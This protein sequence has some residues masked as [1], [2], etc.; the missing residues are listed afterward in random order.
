M[1]F[2]SVPTSIELPL[3]HPRS[4]IREFQGAV[5]LILLQ[6]HLVDSLLILSKMEGVPLFTIILSVFEVLLHRY[7][8]QEDLVVGVDP[9]GLAFEKLEGLTSS[10]QPILPMRLDLSGDPSFIDLLS[11][12]RVM[13][14]EGFSHPE[15]SRESIIE[16]LDPTRSSN[17]NPY[18]QVVFSFQNGEQNGDNAGTVPFLKTSQ[19][20][21]AYQSDLT[22]R[23]IQEGNGIHGRMEYNAC[24]F[25]PE[26]IRRMIGHLQ[27]LLQEVVENPGKKISQYQLLTES[28]R[29]LTLIDWNDTKVKFPQDATLQSLFEEQVERSPD[30]IA[31]V[32]E[33]LSMTYHQLNCKSNQLAH[34]LRNLGVGPDTRVGVCLERSFEMVEALLGVIKSGA[35]YVPLDPEYP[36][37]RLDFMVSDCN[38]LVLLTQFQHRKKLKTNQI[39]VLVLDDPDKAWKLENPTNPSRT[40]SSQNPAYMIYT[41]GSTGK[42][43]GVINSHQGICNRLLWGQ[44]KYPLDKEDAVLQRTTFS[45]DIS[46]WEIFWP[47]LNGVRLVLAKP[48][49]HRDP[50]YL[51]GLIYREKITTMHFVMSMM[52]VFLQI[53][54]LQLCRSLKRVLCSGEAMTP[55]LAGRF[56]ELLPWCELHNLYGPTEAAVEVT[57]FPVTNIQPGQTVVP[58]GKPVANTQV[59][60]LDKSMEPVP[61]GVAGE[62]FLGGIQVALGYWNRPD[63]TAEKFLPDPFTSEGN[64]LYRTGD[65]VRWN[66]QGDLEYLG[67]LDYQIKLRGFRIEL[68]EIETILASHPGIS[69]CVV[70][71]KEDQ[72]G[73]QRLVAYLLPEGKNN[74]ATTDLRDY[75]ATRLPDYMVPS[76]YVFLNSFPMTPNGKLDRKALPD[77]NHLSTRSIDPYASPETTLEK[78][79][80]EIWSEVLRINQV[81]TRDRFLDS[82]GN[83]LLATMVCARINKQLN[84]KIPIQLI[85]DEPTIQG[86]ARVIQD[87]QFVHSILETPLI[88]DPDHSLETPLSFGQERLLYFHQMQPQSSFYN[89]ASVFKLWGLLQIEC[90]E[91]S[92]QLLVQ[93][94]KVLR[95]TYN[96]QNG[97]PIQRANP[98]RNVVLRKYDL[99]SVSE[100]QRQLE[101]NQI[102]QE[103][104]RLPFDLNQ[105]LPIRS[106][107][108]L[109]GD[110]ESFVVLTTHHIASDGQS[111]EIL[112][113]DLSSLYL[114]LI[115][116]QSCHLPALNLQYSDYA[117]WQQKLVHGGAIRKGLDYWKTH[118]AGAPNLLD[119]SLDYPRPAVREFHGNQE[120]IHLDQTLVRGLKSLGLKEG[121]TLFM[122]LITSFEVLLNRYSGHEDI[123]LGVVTSGRSHQ[124]LE[125]LIGFF[126]NTLPMRLD[127]RGDPSFSQLLSRAR[128]MILDGF[129]HQ[130]VP[131]EKIIEEIRPERSL[132]YNPIFQVVF[133][134]MTGVTSKWNFG[135]LSA[136]SQFVRSDSSKFDL[137][138]QLM[139]EGD[140]VRGILEFN[141]DLFRS[142][143]IQRMVGH[144][145]NL[146]KEIVADP[147]KQISQF[148]LMN[149]MERLLI[150]YEWNNTRVSYPRDATIQSLFEAQVAS[151]PET[152]AL[153]Y[154][155]SS[156]TYSELNRRAN[157]LAYYLRNI[158][159]GPDVVVSFFLPRSF[160]QMITILAILKA[161]GC[162]MPLNP[163]D[164]RERWKILLDEAG[165]R[166]L[167]SS[168]QCIN[169]SEFSGV[170]VI[171]LDREMS[172]INQHGDEN[173]SSFNQATDLAYV[174]FTSGSTGKP[175]GVEI[176]HRGVV[177]LL[178][179]VD[180]VKL[181][182]ETITLQLAP[183]SFDASTF[184]IWAPLLH[185][186]RCVIS[187]M[188]TPSSGSIRELIRTNQVNTLWLTSAFFNFLIEEDV[189]CLGS[190]QQLLIGGEAL[191]PRHV[192]L[193][194]SR[195]PQVALVNGYGPTES[196]TF[197]SCYPI[198]S[199]WNGASVPIGRP[200]GNTTVYVVD[201]NRNPVPVGV[202][203]DLYLGGDGL[204]RGYRG[205]PVFTAGKF[206]PD[207]FSG[208]GNLYQTGDRAKW[209][210]DGLLQFVGR[211]D[212][213]VKLRGFRIELGEIETALNARPDIRQ[214]LVVAREDPH[215][216]KRLVAY[217]ITNSHEQPSVLELREYLANKLP[218]YMIPFDYVL[219]DSFPR[220]LNGKIDHNAFPIPSIDR[221]SGFIEFV[222][223]STT[224]EKELTE[225]WRNLLGIQKI[226][227]H[228]N[229][230]YLG[231]H[232]LLV[233]RLLKTVQTMTGKEISINDYL[234]NP[235]IAGITRIIEGKTKPGSSG[236]SDT[237]SALRASSRPILF[238]MD[239]NLI[240]IRNHFP[241]DQP[242]YW[243]DRDY[244][245]DDKV[246]IEELASRR[247]EQ[248]LAIQANGPYYLFG[249]SAGGTIAFEMAQRLIARGETIAFLGLMDSPG[250]IPGFSLFGIEYLWNTFIQKLQNMPRKI[251]QW[252]GARVKFSPDHQNDQNQMIPGKQQDSELME[253]VLNLRNTVAAL[254]QYRPKQYP[255][256]IHLFVAKNTRTPYERK[257]QIAGWE[258][259]AVGGFESFLLDG[260]HQSF[261]KEP[262]LQIT[263]RIFH[264]CLKK[265]Q[266]NYKE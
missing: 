26:T 109:L 214:S 245:F 135:D 201:K 157:Q 167:V 99:R 59:Y 63:L 79:L 185:G 61:V 236:L 113:E 24:H 48:G 241:R 32:F 84:L 209:T 89:M 107:L 82:G 20:I 210:F 72:T 237:A 69:R 23:L 166:F 53:A 170:N 199:N 198:P 1:Q 162:Y 114:A 16:E 261:L 235:T 247:M 151:S 2:G 179:G 133:S 77:P 264:D 208:S 238:C 97:I 188:K 28:E 111:E 217:L 86:L 233:L 222:G 136:E 98:G 121:A 125:N 161:G 243:L 123:V 202:E 50:E 73:G 184:E 30:A 221:S 6:T 244:S 13:T 211:N 37:S 57:Y 78:K 189:H 231:G 45:F 44:S 139:E 187:P 106:A 168:G 126:A 128:K 52:H 122:V 90:L 3:D 213:Q 60:V 55:D 195:N 5:D 51:A 255:G 216:D 71:V 132:S 96:Y 131:L 112:R 181:G 25:G 219:M 242:V 70:L 10:F 178:F 14:L 203:G 145:Q 223:P 176:R 155:E 172:K 191:S 153:V 260:D 229:F 140:S 228:D 87:Q 177:R 146:L 22:L 148:Q 80:V 263:A 207:I 175:K 165:C 196:T 197:A 27:N 95:S 253:K 141:T 67:R 39:P 120:I 212:N 258:K 94:H 85:F 227:I 76:D 100:N 65:R 102:I 36:E 54:D 75:L 143:T 83:S 158:G 159:V 142:E 49:G 58:I 257:V 18:L 225:V 220:T 205:D 35:A 156:L 200:I 190:L 41:S 239:K 4:A 47:L 7:S 81:G 56:L 19:G 226:S 164:P 103:E 218:Q 169:S 173:P 147:G 11:R 15:I 104:T 249:Y 31:L 204:A 116:R 64:K 62:L 138:L 38:P 215:G 252:I 29:K 193:F 34:H 124:D 182:N 66:H 149:E 254:K 108:I 12:V 137:T 192:L 92:I 230:F 42:P 46:V 234:A 127:L 183:L 180:Y 186:G 152:I 163:E 93:R 265:A 101:T 160:D 129:S 194:L 8:G 9:A 118:L 43:K 119:L 115:S 171:C 88:R 256:R 134:Y 105:D 150:L 232:S 21:G 246:T 240:Q 117:I 248:L 91:Q 110:Q 130:E 206:I 144:F 259:I 174:L 251:I 33:G 17:N 262:L 266:N 250:P 224:I 40:I 74:L 154:E 68:G